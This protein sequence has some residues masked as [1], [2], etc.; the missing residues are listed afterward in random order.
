MPVDYSL[1]PTPGAGA[2]GHSPIKRAQL[3][4]RRRPLITSF[5]SLMLFLAVYVSIFPSHPAQLSSAVGSSW[6]SSAK[7]G[8]SGSWDPDDDDGWFSKISGSGSKSSLA[9]DR[10]KCEQLWQDDGRLATSGPP[11]T[12]G[13][14]GVTEG[15][16]SSSSSSPG[17]VVSGPVDG[18]KAEYSLEEEIRKGKTRKEALKEMVAK[19]NG[20]YVRDYPLYVFPSAR[21]TA[22]TELRDKLMACSHPAPLCSW[23]GWNNIRYIIEVR[24]SAFSPASP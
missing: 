22:S 9:V 24:P 8:S 12:S 17:G 7:T 14:G 15:S 2:H 16:S 11:P 1:L 19:T 5:V 6:S 23:L 18:G 13:S 20:Y 3:F 4:L 10:Q 21:S